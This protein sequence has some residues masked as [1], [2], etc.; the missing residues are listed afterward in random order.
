MFVPSF[1][2]G[3]CEI[4]V[5]IHKEANLSCY[6]DDRSRF[7]ERGPKKLQSVYMNKLADEIRWSKEKETLG[8][9]RGPYE[10]PYHETLLYLLSHHTLYMYIYQV[11]SHPLHSKNVIGYFNRGPH[12]PSPHPNTTTTTTTNGAKP[13]ASKLF[14]FPMDK[15]CYL[16]LFSWVSLYFQNHKA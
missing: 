16:S 6:Y 1:L 12:L 8:F 4:A 13:K 14:Q 10:Y 9:R 15:P 11:L 2:S 5:I 7:N 3:K